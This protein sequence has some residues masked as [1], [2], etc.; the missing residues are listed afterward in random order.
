MISGLEAQAQAM[1][2][3]HAE[4]L[5]RIVWNRTGQYTHMRE[6]DA[7]EAFGREEW[8]LMRE[9]LIPTVTVYICAQDG[10]LNT[11]TD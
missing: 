5:F 6:G 1:V 3:P 4:R 9:N 11:T 2:R 8:E 10:D 7:L